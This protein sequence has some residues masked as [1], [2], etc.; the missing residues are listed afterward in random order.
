MDIE[1]IEV[2]AA[3]SKLLQIR[4]Q[5]DQREIYKN[6]SLVVIPQGQKKHPGVEVVEEGE[7]GVE[8]EEGVDVVV[9]EEEGMVVMMKEVTTRDQDKDIH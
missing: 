6:I 3:K 4:Q 7:V 2:L 9:E 1:V 8:E 5:Q